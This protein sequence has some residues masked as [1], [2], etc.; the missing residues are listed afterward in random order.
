MIKINVKWIM[1]LIVI[2]GGLIGNMIYASW[3][4]RQEDKR[5]AA[6]VEYVNRENVRQDKYTLS[7]NDKQDCVIL[8]LQTDLKNKVEIREFESV[9][10]DIAVIREDIKEILILLTPEK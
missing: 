9:K 4:Y 7:Q 2:I 8:R 1:P 10:T 6:S 5:A 3:T